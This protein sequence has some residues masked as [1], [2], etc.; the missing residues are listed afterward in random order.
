[1][2]R[3]L[4]DALEKLLT[5]GDEAPASLF[6][7]AQRAALDVLARGTGFLIARPQGRGVAYRI[8][9]RAGL[10]AHLRTLRPE[11]PATVPRD[12][13]QR[14]AN[15]ATHR[16]SKAGLATHSFHYF[17][18]KAVGNGVCWTHSDDRV[19]DLSAATKSAGAGVLAI[20]ES[21]AWQSDCPLWLVENQAIFDD[22]SWLPQ[23]TRAS[24]GY[25]AGQIPSRLVTW[26]AQRSRVP[27]VILFADYDG[28]GL[29]NFV[30]LR[31]QLTTSCSFWLMPNWHDLLRKYGSNRIWH[32]THQEFVAATTRLAALRPPADLLELCAAMSREGLAL[33][34]EAVW[35]RGSEAE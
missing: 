16:D 18:L 21:D 28:I 26:L 30:R 19:L 10:E 2:S 23:H 32:N 14:A 11:T 33:E 27:E 24:I 29:Q 17:L 34:H 4:A 20:Q 13:P 25:Y 3:A 15:I 5:Q 9:N 22:T 35:L 6:T 7:P 1:M 31:E 12:I 8:G